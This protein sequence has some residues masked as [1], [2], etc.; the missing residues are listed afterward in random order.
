MTLPQ[1]P[2]LLD[3]T[4]TQVKHPVP[5]V[6]KVSIAQTRSG[7]PKNA[8]SALTKTRWG[9]RTAKRVPLVPS[10]RTLLPLLKS[11]FQVSLLTPSTPSAT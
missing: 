3:S 11:A 9:K 8:P 6:R 5:N 4:P 1:C 10:A 2:A 7:S